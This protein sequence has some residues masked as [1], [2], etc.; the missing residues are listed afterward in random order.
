MR[1]KCRNPFYERKEEKGRTERR[2]KDGT[3]RRRK[4]RKEGKCEEEKRKMVLNVMR[5]HSLQSA[6]G[7]RMYNF[8][9]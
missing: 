4:E 8:R 9:N 3:E 7:R 1:P 6:E 5:T 2:R